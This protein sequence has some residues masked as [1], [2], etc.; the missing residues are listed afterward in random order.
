[1]STF[2]DWRSTI[3]V[4][5]LTFDVWRS[6]F[7]DRR[8][9][10]DVRHLT[11]DV[12]RFTFDV[13]RSTFDVRRLTYEVWRST[14]ETHLKSIKWSSVWLPFYETEWWWCK[15]LT[16]TILF[17]YFYF[18]FLSLLYGANNPSDQFGRLPNDTLEILRLDNK[19]SW[20]LNLD[21]R[22]EKKNKD[23]SIKFG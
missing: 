12:R 15:V 1:M 22:K 17:C 2:D 4:R 3:D 21:K 18:Y 13:W 14:F 11:F 7:E 19:R 6:T 20:A 16:W 9:T 10:F 8:L 5:R 23:W